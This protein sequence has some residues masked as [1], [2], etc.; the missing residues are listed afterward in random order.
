MQK[1]RMCPIVLGKPLVGI[2]T[3]TLGMPGAVGV[4]VN[5]IQL[6]QDRTAALLLP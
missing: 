5:R 2:P 3:L 6:G 1:I 4:A